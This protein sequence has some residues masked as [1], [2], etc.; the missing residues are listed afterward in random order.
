M[1]PIAV[2][3]AHDARPVYHRDNHLVDFRS[4]SCTLLENLNEQPVELE[5]R[6]GYVDGNLELSV[7]AGTAA[8]I[9]VPGTLI[10]TIVDAIL[11]RCFKSRA[12]TA[13]KYWISYQIVWLGLLDLVRH[14]SLLHQRHPG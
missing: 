3:A 12:D 8:H 11:Q 9:E 7:F 14:G 1:Q 4:I 6:S 5:G 2:V 13:N 10:V